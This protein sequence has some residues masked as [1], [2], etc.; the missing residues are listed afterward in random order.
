M[1]IVV[2]DGFSGRSL[3]QR[4]LQIGHLGQLGVRLHWQRISLV[5][6]CC[7]GVDK[8]IIGVGFG[9][10]LWWFIRFV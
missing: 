10:G 7:L 2:L 9:G 8:D 1:Q 6:G 5:D 3:G 4:R